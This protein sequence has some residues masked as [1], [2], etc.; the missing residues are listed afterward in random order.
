MA[1]QSLRGKLQKQF[2][3]YKNYPYGFSRSGDFS[4]RESKILQEQGRL[5]QALWDGSLSPE[6]DEETRFVAMLNGQREPESEAEKVWVKYLK[7]INRPHIGAL[8]SGK[9]DDVD[10]GNSDDLSDDDTVDVVDDSVDD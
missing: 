6:S 1:A 9:P 3:D 7:R 8:N 10:D 5:F 4:I 2:N